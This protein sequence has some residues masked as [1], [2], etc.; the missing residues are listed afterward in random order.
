[1]NN[2]G[3][4][5]FSFEF[6]DDIF[7]DISC[8]VNTD[9]KNLWSMTFPPANI[10]LKKNKDLF[11]NFAIAGYSQED[12]ELSFEGDKMILELKNGKTE[13]EEGDTYLIRGIRNSPQKGWYYVPVAKYDTEKAIASVKDGLLKIEIP[14]KE[15]AKPK[16]VKIN[17]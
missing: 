13:K 15:E 5:V 10:I 17:L 2:N 6:F 9:F 12:V 1:M 11:F 3:H 7:K 14:V 4:N 8:V 16:K